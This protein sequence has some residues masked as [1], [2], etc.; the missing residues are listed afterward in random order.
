MEEQQVSE[1]YIKCSACKCN[2]INDDA[3]VN[4]YFGYNRLEEIYN[5]CVKCKG[6]RDV[7]DSSDEDKEAKDKAQ[8]THYEQT[9]RQRNFEKLT[10]GTCGESVCRNAKRRHER[11]KGCV[12]DPS[13]GSDE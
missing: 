6:K 8:H 12:F 7:Y 5:T 9:G 1:T 3:H 4:T 10:C 2:Y 13:V 11:Y